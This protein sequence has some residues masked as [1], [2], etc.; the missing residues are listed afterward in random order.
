MCFTR[1]YHAY[2]YCVILLIFGN[3][4]YFYGNLIIFTAIYGSSKVFTVIGVCCVFSS[5]LRFLLGVF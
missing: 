2:F 4:L 1:S 5:L 3:I